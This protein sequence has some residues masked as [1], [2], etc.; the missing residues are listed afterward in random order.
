MKGAAPIKLARK[1]DK[2]SQ[3]QTND[4]GQRHR[5]NKAK[6]IYRFQRWQSR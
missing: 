2:D 5:G 4:T 3:H 1:D 6:S